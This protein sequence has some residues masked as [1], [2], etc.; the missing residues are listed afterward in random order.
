MSL[1]IADDWLKTAQLTERELLQEIVLMLFKQERITLGQA[2]TWLEIDRFSFQ[3]LLAAR[4]IPVHY[5][6]ADYQSD[7]DT[8]H[9]QG[10]N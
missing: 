2:S 8:I 7:M 3:Q 5:G 9:K 4:Q 1:V 10:W 6:I